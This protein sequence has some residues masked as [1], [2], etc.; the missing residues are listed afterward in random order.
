MRPLEAHCNFSL[1]KL[2]LKAQSKAA[3][4]ELAKASVLYSDMNMRFWLAEAEKA[5][6]EAR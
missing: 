5:L 3:P 2:Y 1:G 6:A 4:H